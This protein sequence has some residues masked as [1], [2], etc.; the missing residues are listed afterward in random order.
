MKILKT[1]QMIFALSASLLILSTFPFLQ[2][3]S[4]DNEIKVTAHNRDNFQEISISDIP[5]G[6]VPKNVNSS[7]LEKI[8]NDISKIYFKNERVTRIT[9]TDIGKY[10]VLYKNT[11]KNTRFKAQGEYGSNT[12]EGSWYDIVVECSCPYVNSPNVM[13]TSRVTN[14][15][16]AYYDWHQQ[17]AIGKWGKDG[18]SW[19]LEYE[20]TATVD[21][22]IYC[23]G[24]YYISRKDVFVQGLIYFN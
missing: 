11:N 16:G 6:I 10:E 15:V 5:K 14:F 8:K 21:Q 13:L 4:D 20:I 3:C 24:K 2:S 18:D 17:R 9:K 23:N 19:Y 22:Y 7:D 12:K 1:K